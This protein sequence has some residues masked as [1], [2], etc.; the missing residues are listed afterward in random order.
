[1]NFTLIRYISN[2]EQ[3]CNI[4]CKKYHLQFNR[5]LDTLKKLF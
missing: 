4:I 2:I 5:K 3:V 1:M